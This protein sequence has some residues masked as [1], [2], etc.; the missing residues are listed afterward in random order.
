MGIKHEKR[1]KEKNQEIHHGVKGKRRWGG[2]GWGRKGMKHTAPAT[3]T[4]KK[5]GKKHMGL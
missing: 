5:G 3:K 2:V 4:K 1:K